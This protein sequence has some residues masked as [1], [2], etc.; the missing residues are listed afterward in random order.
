MVYL[1]VINGSRASQAFIRHVGQSFP[2]NPA[3]W[4]AY[5]QSAR[6][7]QFLL[8]DLEYQNEMKHYTEKDWW[9][10]MKVESACFK[11]ENPND[12]LFILVNVENT[13]KIINCPMGEEYA[14]GEWHFIHEN[15]RVKS[16][17][18]FEWVLNPFEVKIVRFESKK[19]SLNTLVNK[20]WEGNLIRDFS[21]EQ[22]TSP[23]IPTACYLHMS[24]EH[25]ATAFLDR[26]IAHHGEVSLRLN[27]LGGQTP[28]DNS[29]EISFYQFQTVANHA[30][31][32]S[33]WAYAEQT[34][35]RL[36][37]EN[38]IALRIEK[39]WGKFIWH[40]TL[41]IQS[42]WHRY[43]V[44]YVPTVGEDR[45]M[46]ELRLLEEGFVWIDQVQWVESPTITLSGQIFDAQRTLS[47]Q[48]IGEICPL[49]K[50]TYVYRPIVGDTIYRGNL[51]QGLQ[52]DKDGVVEVQYL[53][54]NG[55]FQT[56]SWPVA[57]NFKKW[58]KLEYAIEPSLKYLASG[59]Q[60]L[61]DGQM[62][63]FVW[64]GKW[65]GFEGTDFEVVLEKEP[66]EPCSLIT[67]SALSKKSAWVYWPSSVTLSASE[68]GI[69]FQE[70]Q[71]INVPNQ[72]YS[73]DDGVKSFSFPLVSSGKGEMNKW[74][75][76][77]LQA[78]SI[79]KLPADHPFVG[80]KSW[81][82]IDEILLR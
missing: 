53:L 2:K 51:S 40:D 56:M 9:G 1:G 77:K 41:S 22:W 28:Q 68:D 23:A 43:D 29:Q 63:E 75:Y 60:A 45:N 72:S 27:N 20:E 17:E 64:D 30:Y 5:H 15:R 38:K 32:L 37:E 18:M 74:R 81:L 42:G 79:K 71:T 14:N 39:P 78:K 24:K 54:P 82:F 19:L 3:M 16:D 12:R 50:I 80:E 36:G 7:L 69:Q 25:G 13:H 57:L 73:D 21:F 48:A 55:Q 67:M 58:S 8:K 59:K 70:I 65:Q 35:S 47:A 52:L 4:S 61:M 62:G 33:F 11:G 44:S 66:N 10:K 76:F 26:S 31:V 34:G 49:E 46:L 6:E